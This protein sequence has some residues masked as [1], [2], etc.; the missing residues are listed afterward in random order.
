MKNSLFY[1]AISFFRIYF[2]DTFLFSF[3][4]K[5]IATNSLRFL[6]CH[7]PLFTHQLLHYL[8]DCLAIYH[9]IWYLDKN[10]FDK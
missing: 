8:P 9:S 5:V 10:N 7:S 3:M 2:A 1:K 6:L 4:Q